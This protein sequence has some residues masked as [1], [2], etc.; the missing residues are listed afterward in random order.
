MLRQDHGFV[1]TR[2]HALKLA[3]VSS[4]RAAL[5]ARIRVIVDTGQGERSIYKTVGTSGSFGWSDEPCEHARPL[6]RAFSP[7]RP[8]RLQLRRRR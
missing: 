7:A 8:D 3:G 4:N 1:R 5:G 2:Q 6:N